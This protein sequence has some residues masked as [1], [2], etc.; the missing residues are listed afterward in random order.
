MYC[1]QVLCAV[2]AGF[3]DYFLLA[4]FA[5]MCIEGIQLYFM[6]VEVFEAEKSR[7][8]WFYISGYGKIATFIEQFSINILKL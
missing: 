1:G 4:S 3:L 7:A 2:I 8:I 5:W 6:L